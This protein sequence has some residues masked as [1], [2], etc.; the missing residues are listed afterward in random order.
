MPDDLEVRVYREGV[1]AGLAGDHFHRNH[2]YP[3]LSHLDLDVRR[4]VRAL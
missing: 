4:R 3:G 1:A 2:R